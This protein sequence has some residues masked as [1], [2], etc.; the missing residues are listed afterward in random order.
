MTV[1][2]REQ[3]DKLLNMYK[4]KYAAF[5]GALDLGDMIPFV[6]FVLEETEKAER[7]AARRL[8]CMS[9]G[10]VFQFNGDGPTGSFELSG[11]VVTSSGWKLPSPVPCMVCGGKLQIVHEDVA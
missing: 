9:N 2:S 8:E 3:L 11:G 1:L 10:H 7:R 6:E 5:G 4:S